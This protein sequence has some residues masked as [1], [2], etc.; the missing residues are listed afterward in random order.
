MQ[1]QGLVLVG[2]EEGVIGAGHGGATATQE[3][4]VAGT[5]FLRLGDG[6]LACLE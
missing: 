4:L 1:D 3:R 5:A 2:L 6:P